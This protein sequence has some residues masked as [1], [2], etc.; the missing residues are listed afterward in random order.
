MK[1]TTFLWILRE[2]KNRV[3]SDRLL[4]FRKGRKEIVVERISS[5]DFF[6]KDKA[7]ILGDFVLFRTKAKA[8]LCVLGQIINFSF[9]GKTKA[10][11]R[12]PFS[13]CIL[14]KNKNVVVTLSPCFL[15]SKNGKFE[16]CYDVIYDVSEYIASTK[17][18]HANFEKFC[19]EKNIL[20]KL[21]NFK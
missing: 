1:K 9:Q 19:F 15:V 17:K 2:E 7:L 11:R 16:N 21:K 4:R 14:E 20:Q 18:D 3:S 13:H 12:F 5:V 8:K 6:F 10:E